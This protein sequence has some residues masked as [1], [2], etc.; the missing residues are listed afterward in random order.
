MMTEMERKSGHKHPE[1]ELNA[2]DRRLLRSIYVGA[3]DPRGEDGNMAAKSGIERITE[4][5]TVEMSDIQS[6]LLKVFE[7]GVARLDPPERTTGNT[8]SI[9]EVAMRI[10]RIRKLRRE[11]FS[12]ELFHERAWDMLLELF[13]AHRSN[14][15]VWV[16]SLLGAAD[17]SPTTAIRWLDHLEASGLI[18][19]RSDDED[20]RRVIVDL[21]HKGDQAMTAYLQ[22]ARSVM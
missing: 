3:R 2:K 16:K 6:R 4:N 15:D 10:A 9:V 8:T 7:E 13:I 1:R 20:R 11:Y 14:R 19:R 17:G 5:L 18:V 12:A 22:E 21:T